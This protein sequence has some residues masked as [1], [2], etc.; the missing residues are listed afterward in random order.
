MSDLYVKYETSQSFGSSLW[1]RS[2][3]VTFM[4]NLRAVVTSK[5][6]YVNPKLQPLNDC[7]LCSINCLIY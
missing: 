1:D 4:L 6:G 2:F 5:L 3:L 7:D